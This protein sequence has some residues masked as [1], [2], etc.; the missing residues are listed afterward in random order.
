MNTIFTRRSIR[1]YKE[2]KIDDES[3]ER[4]LKAAMQAPSSGNQQPWEF[5]VVQKQENL[6]K[7]SKLSLYAKML[8]NASLAIVLLANESRMKYEPYWQQDMSAAAQNILLEATELGLGAVW[9][10]VAPLEDRVKYVEN[11]FNLK[12]GIRPFAVISIGYLA[13]GQEN[14]F[15]DRFDK[16]RIH[17]EN[18]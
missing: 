12:E 2:G 11:M 6:R 18:Y 16:S 9:L 5:I 15:I 13:N 3:I 7:L 4:M 17:Y 1:K 14:K 10:G 8:E